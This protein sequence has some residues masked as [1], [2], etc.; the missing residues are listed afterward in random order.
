MFFRLYLSMYL[1]QFPI[2]VIIGAALIV[3]FVRTRRKAFLAFITALVLLAL[4]DGIKFCHEV[5]GGALDR[6]IAFPWHT[7]WFCRDI[8]I[9]GWPIILV[10]AAWVVWRHNR[11]KEKA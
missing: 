7:Y 8:M 9:F 10:T 4:P 3:L 5:L 1:W 11:T 6:Y 2:F